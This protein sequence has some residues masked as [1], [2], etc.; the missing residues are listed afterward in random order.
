MASAA[1]LAILITADVA[2]V[3]KALDGIS[4]QIENTGKS[5]AGVSGKLGGV[6]QEISKSLSAFDGS[7]IAAEAADAAKG[8][9]KIGGVSNLTEKELA[10]VRSTTTEAVAKFK[11]MGKEV[12]PDIARLSEELEKAGSSTSSLGDKSSGLASK[13]GELSKGMAV[14]GTAVVGAMA[15]IGGA[16]LAVG[17]K[18]D[19]AFDGMA[20]KTGATGQA[21]EGLQDSFKNVIG[22]TPADFETV[23]A[24]MGT[25]SQRTGATGKE[26]ETLTTQV[27]DLSRITGVDATAAATAA[28]DVFAKWGTTGAD[29]GKVMDQLFVASQQTGIGFDELAASV[30]TNASALQAGGLG[31]RESIGLIS[32]LKSA[33]ID[34]S[35][36][37]PK[38]GKAMAKMVKEG[39][40]PA[41]G[42]SALFDTIKAEGPNSAAAIEAL[43][44]AGLKL[45][46]GIASGKVE[47]GAFSEALAS[48]SGAISD[49]AADTADFGE[50]IDMMK[51]KVLVA[52]E[53]LGAVVMD[54]VTKF[55]DFLLPIVDK[56]SDGFETFIDMMQSSS[57]WSSSLG[58]AI[59]ESL[60]EALGGI[61]LSSFSGWIDTIVANFD[62]IKEAIMGI[63]WA[64]IGEQ[65]MTFAG[66]FMDGLGVVLPIIAGIFTNV[67]LPVIMTVFNFFKEH[68]TLLAVIG[69]AFLALTGPIGAIVVALTVLG[70]LGP[71]VGEWVGAIASGLIDGIGAIVGGVVGAVTA[72][73]DAIIDTF[74]SLLG[75]ASPSQVFMDFGVNLLQG[76]IDGVISMV[77]TVVSTFGVLHDAIAAAWET[78][79]ATVMATVEIIRVFISAKW[80]AI[81][82][83]LSAKLEAISKTVTD[84]WDAVSKTIDTAMNT[85]RDLINSAWDAIG[86]VI[87]DALNL[88]E[89]LVLDGMNFIETK[90]GVSMDAVRNIFDNAM[91]AIHFAVDAVV[92]FLKGD[93]GDA[94]EFA[95]LAAD[96]A[97]DAIKGYF[98]AGW[99]AIK[100]ILNMDVLVAPFRDGMGELTRIGGQL[101]DGLKAG[102]SKGW[103]TLRAWM[104]GMFGDI[105]ALAKKILGIASPSKVMAKEIGE[106]MALG[107]V[108]GMQAGL[109]ANPIVGIVEDWTKALRP[110]EVAK[111]VTPILGSG[112]GA[113]ISKAIS[114]AIPELVSS[115]P[116]WGTSGAPGSLRSSGANAKGTGW[117]GLNQG[118]MGNKADEGRVR[119]DAFHSGKGGHLAASSSNYWQVFVAKWGVPTEASAR[120]VSRQLGIPLPQWLLDIYN[121]PQGE[122]VDAPD[123]LKDPAP[124]ME[125]GHAL[126][127][128]AKVAQEV[129]DALKAVPVRFALEVEKA[130]GIIGKAMGGLDDLIPRMG[131]S[132]PRMRPLPPG[133]IGGPIVI[134]PPGGASTFGAGGGYGTGSVMLATQTVNL[135]GPVS[136]GFTGTF[137]VGGGRSLAVELVDALIADTG[138]FD[139]LIRAEDNRRAQ[140]P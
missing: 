109:S 140:K 13:L 111:L 5:V 107:I 77:A 81:G 74:C 30:T 67:L 121:P 69:A 65:V 91:S 134:D 132:N 96:A 126:E 8:I 53:P 116:A 101:I 79:K 129:A 43:G 17:G 70:A 36:V 45:A 24:A 27:S 41:E 64:G 88:I 110:G 51:N 78:I 137:Q 83:Y 80:D 95:K 7:K 138:T 18:F 60:G 31:M 39:Q 122:T 112:I 103:D 106:P 86:S 14:G 47:L 62:A 123:V 4:S 22:N 40:D 26:L 19:D 10:S 16:L 56:V 108:A 118:G 2:G 52:L 48:S 71:K 25:L 28:A 97:W 114:A 84:A 89:S 61:D 102:I 139:K 100:S 55:T 82:E 50:R 133:G 44:P 120:K 46:A 33:G 54:L 135:A 15:G 12:P 58:E 93:W 85:A 9:E 105:I 37:M 128:L 32:N 68:T 127:H 104:E 49:T 119:A 136:V 117:S 11:A 42:L 21:L 125:A 76:L 124:A 131:D 3:S 66:Y 75:I 94:L 1:E 57:E 113:A 98:S 92:A 63:D 59:T 34:A 23:S 29:Q 72:V 35:E 6:G 38:L 73:V 87:H 90:T 115:D 130:A 20:V 99:D